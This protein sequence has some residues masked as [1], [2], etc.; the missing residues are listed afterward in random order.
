MYMYSTCR[1]PE[2]DREKI[3]QSHQSRH[4]YELTLLSLSTLQESAP[5]SPGGEEDLQRFA[6]Y[7]KRSHKLKGI[8]THNDVIRCNM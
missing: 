1:L 7:S 3:K 2:G 8:H 6:N 5:S 4:A